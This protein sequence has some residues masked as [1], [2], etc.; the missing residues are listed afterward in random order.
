MKKILKYIMAMTAGAFLA[1]SCDLNIEPSNSSTGDKIADSPTGITDVLNGCYATFIEQAGDNAWYLRQFFQFGD[2]SSDDVVY[3]HETEDELDYIFRFSKRHAGLG[4]V[5]AFWAQSYKI[6]YGANVAIDL[7]SKAEES[8]TNNYLKGEALFLKAFA[9]HSLVRLYALPYSE[10]NK[11][12]P[13]LIIRY[14]NLDA[15]NKDRET[16]EATY[17]HIEKYLLEAEKLMEEN[18]CDRSDDKSFASLGAVQALLSRVYLYMG[19]WDDCITYSTKVI[20]GDYALEDAEGIKDYYTR[21][22][23]SDETIW[24]IRFQ[25]IDDKESGAIAS[26][27]YLGSGCWGEEGYSTPLLEAMGSKNPDLKKLDSRWSF[28]GYDEDGVHKEFHEKNGLKLYPCSK[29]SWQDGKITLSSPVMFR[30]SEMYFNRAEA[31]AHSGGSASDA[32]DDIN[33]VRRN[34]LDEAALPEGR[35]IDDYL[36]KEADGELIDLILNEKRIEF[37][38]EAHRFFDLVRNGRD[39]VRNYW[40]YHVDSFVTGQ[41]I[42]TPPGEAAAGVTIEAGNSKLVMPVPTQERSNNTLCSQNAGY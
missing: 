11:T 38:F 24:C 33:E 17:G 16:L 12:T 42:T 41:D 26:M 34:R 27:I 29:F 39:I 7:V 35:T 21:A 15:E 1:A 14:D 40:G 18:D 31:I 28:V 10:A 4:N 25:T 19:R 22:Y 36:I 5:T 8:E 23:D 37:A 9:M 20:D 2:F 13:G 6:I 3:G 32:V 30:L